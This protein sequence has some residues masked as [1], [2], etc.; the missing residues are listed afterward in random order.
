MK[1]YHVMENIGKCKYLVNYH[2]GKKTHKDGSEFYDIALFKNKKALSKFV[3]E[4]HDSNYI[5]R[6]AI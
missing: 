3:K 2:D 1:V 5:Y 4:L 6:R